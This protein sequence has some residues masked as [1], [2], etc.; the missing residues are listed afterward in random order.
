MVKFLLDCLIR[1]AA[2]LRTGYHVFSGRRELKDRL[3]Y[4]RDPGR[5]R[6]FILGNGPGL[7]GDEERLRDAIRATDSI[8]LNRFA[9]SELFTRLQPRLYVLCDPVFCGREADVESPGLLA[10]RRKLFEAIRSRL[11]WDMTLL[12]PSYGKSEIA[13]RLSHPRLKV[14]PF[15]S[16]KLDHRLMAW[17]KYPLLRKNWACF[18]LNNVMVAS[19]YLSINLGYREIILVGAD[20]SWSE[21]M[22]VDDQN[23][24]CMEDPHFYDGA[25]KPPQV[26]LSEGRAPYGAA[27][28]FQDLVNTF[29]MYQELQGYARKMGVRVWNASSRS[30]IDAFERL[31][32]IPPIQP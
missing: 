16:A 2:L 24:I 3:T 8:G 4:R 20:H 6:V 15:N 9:E 31:R 12:V 28:F 22:R 5:R 21:Q 32:E 23:R 13:D 14:L 30:Y 27:A 17:I 10:M 29:T 1:I 11:D 26:V 7:T 25:Q 19:I 18:S